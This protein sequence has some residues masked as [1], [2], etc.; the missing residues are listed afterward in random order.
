MYD[1]A[2]VGAGPAGSTLAYRLSSSGISTCIIDRASFPRKKT[3][4]GGLP[5]SIMRILPFDIS[6]VIENEVTAIRLT[7]KMT[8]EF[9]RTYAVPLLYTVVRQVFDDFSL[10]KAV[11]AG[12]V[13]REN[14]RVGKITC[15]GDTYLIGTGKEELRARILV[16]ADGANGVTAKSIGLDPIDSAHLAVQIE[17]PQEK[18]GRSGSFGQTISLAW[19]FLEDGYGWLFPNGDFVSIGVMGPSAMGRSVKSYL[20]EWV[21]YFGLSPDEFKIYAHTIPHRTG[22]RPITSG[23]A[24]LIGDAPISGPAGEYAMR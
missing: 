22:R 8:K 5:P 18:L 24:L 15:A 17:V 7:H 13:F 19:G 10:R 14:E 11:D 21:R 23:R 3:C 6:P 16:G 12:A 2:I 1:V 4:A 20:A 9:E